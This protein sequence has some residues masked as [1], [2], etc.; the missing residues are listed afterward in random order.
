MM[1]AVG[2]IQ[3]QECH[4]NTC[5]V[6]VATQDPK[7]ARALDVPDKTERVRRYQEARG[8]GGGA[9]HGVDGRSTTRPSWSR[10]T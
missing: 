9:D 10:T 6:G 4:L 7:R 8:E 2:C 5:P 3:S 1:M